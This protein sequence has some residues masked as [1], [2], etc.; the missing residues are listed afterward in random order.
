MVDAESTRLRT[1]TLPPEFGPQRG[2]G[3]GA[4]RYESE[5]TIDADVA[6]AWDR[7]ALIM[8]RLER[9]PDATDSDNSNAFFAVA[10]RPPLGHPLRTLSA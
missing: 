5:E 3:V 8:S 6:R 10:W 4:S 9:F 7:L 2:H 1:G